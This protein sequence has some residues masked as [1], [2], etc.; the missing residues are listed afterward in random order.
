ME[1][2]PEELQVL[3]VNMTAGAEIPSDVTPAFFGCMHALSEEVV[4]CVSQFVIPSF[5]EC[6]LPPMNIISAISPY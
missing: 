3:V 2:I 4:G 6:T 1:M 5:E